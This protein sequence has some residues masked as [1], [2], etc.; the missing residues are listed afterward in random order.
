M[1]LALSS[2]GIRRIKNL[3]LPERRAINIREWSLSSSF[4]AKFGVL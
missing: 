1:K 4:S 3:I 2:G